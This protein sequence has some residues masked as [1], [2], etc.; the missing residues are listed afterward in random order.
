MSAMPT[1]IRPPVVDAYD[2]TPCMFLV[3]LIRGAMERG[4][5]VDKVSLPTRF[6]D[7]LQREALTFSTP[8]MLV[9][10]VRF[11]GVDLVFED[12]HEGGQRP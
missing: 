3:K 2:L 1:W 4:E 7:H 5:T 9:P 10:P 8:S 12:Y 6:L 11:M